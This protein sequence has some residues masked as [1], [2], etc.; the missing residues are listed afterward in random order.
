MTCFHPLTAYK[1]TERSPAS[2]KYGIVFNPVKALI[3]GSSFKLPCGQCVGCRA[4]KARD[5]GVRVYHEGQLHE[6]KAFLTLTYSD[7]HVPASFSV[8]KR[9]FQL[10]MK[11][12]RKR[13]GSGIKY[14]A[15]GEYGDQTLRPHYHAVC[16]G[17]DFP[18]KYFWRMADG[19]RVYRSPTLEE[20]WPFGNCEIGSVT[21][22][23][24]G[25][26]ARYCTKK[27]TGELAVEHYLRASP[28]DGKMHRVEPEFGLTSRRPALGLNWLRRFK[29]DVFPANFV[30]IDGKPRPVPRYY[31]KKLG[32]GEQATL[33]RDRL[34]RDLA[35]I[36]ARKRRRADSTKERLAVREIVHEDRQSR[37][38][39]TLK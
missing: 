18:D 12:V 13:F 21:L 19:H 34:R 14:L 15:V 30:V 28:I 6:R 22:Q 4:D 10:F 33:K 2:G 39:R 5:L 20:L 3:E 35:D 7:D 25:Y 8:S 9:D 37:L 1:S 26:V 24:A 32:E 38:V 36:P 29:G 23:S 17:L 11:R 31:L 27:L 16:L